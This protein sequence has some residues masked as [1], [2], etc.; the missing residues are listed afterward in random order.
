MEQAELLQLFYGYWQI[1]VCTFAGVALLAIWHHI[2]RGNALL[3]RDPGLFWLAI[4]VLVWGLSGWVEVAQVKHG[5]D[6]T[7]DHLWFEGWKSMLSIF[8]S[9]FI[10]LALP[11][12]RHLPRLIKPIVQSSSWSILVGLSFAFASI[13]TLLMLAGWIVPIKAQFIYAI[14]LAFAIFILFF[15]GLTLWTSFEKRGLR[16]LAYLAVLSIAFTLLAQILKLTDAPFYKLLLN[17]TFKTILITLFFALA[18]SW[19]EELVKA[20][21]KHTNT[22]AFLVFNKHKNGTKWVYELI[23]HLAPHLANQRLVLT[24]KNYALL[25]AFA[26]NRKETPTGGWLEIQPKSSTGKTYD[27]KDYNEINRLLTNLLQAIPEATEAQKKWL[28]DSLFEYGKQRHIRLC[29]APENIT[30]SAG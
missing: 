30:M 27:I 23:L 9:A 1:S 19:V 29:L 17:G 10:L 25:E 14:D 26:K 21:L 7:A 18:L 4:S 2:T 3:E 15:L 11:R 28:K 24:E 22:A 6:N 8:N 16:L 12:F 20:D 5:G 13:L